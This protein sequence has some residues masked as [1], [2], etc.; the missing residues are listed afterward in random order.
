MVYVD[1]SRKVS[2]KEQ[3]KTKNLAFRKFIVGINLSYW[4]VNKNWALNER[5]ESE[6]ASYEASSELSQPVFDLWENFCIAMFP[7]RRFRL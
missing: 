7:I 5:V 3:L 6:L 4:L 2:K 1:F